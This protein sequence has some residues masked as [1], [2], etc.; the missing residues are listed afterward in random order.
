MLDVGCGSGVLGLLFA[1]HHKRSRVVGVD[2]NQQ[3][4]ETMNLNAAEMGL[5]KVEAVCW[6]V[7]GRVE[8][9]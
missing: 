8:F 5:D 9:Q 3:A 7:C 4:V 2:I 1:K 6:D